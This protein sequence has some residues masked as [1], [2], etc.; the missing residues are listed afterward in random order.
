MAAQTDEVHGAH[1]ASLQHSVILCVYSLKYAKQSLT[2]EQKFVYTWLMSTFNRML[3]ILLLGV[4]YIVSAQAA[5]HALVLDIQGAIGSAVAEDVQQAL[6]RAK[7]ADSSLLILRMDTPGGLDLSMRSIIKDILASPVPVATFV[8]PK[9]ARAASAGTY[10][11]YASHIAAMAPA[12]NLGAATPVRIG[13]LPSISPPAKPGLKGK[14]EQRDG[15][16]HGDSMQHKMV[17]DAAAYM[18]GLAVLRGRNAD[19]AEKAVRQAASLNS[20]QA[21]QA[22]VIDVIAEDI[23]ALLKKLDGRTIDTSYG[24]VTL[25]SSNLA[26]EVVERNWRSRLLAI[27]SN[28]NVA[29]ILMLLAIYGLFFE[30]ANPGFVLPGIVGGVC[31][32]LALF[33]FQVLPVNLAGVGLITL[34]ILFMVGEVFAPSFG[35]LGLGGIIAFVV[36]SIMLMDSSV[37]GYGIS[38]ALIIGFTLSSVLFFVFTV[39]MAL[40]A[41]QRPVVSGAEEMLGTLAIA[42]DD[43]QANSG[44]VLA[45]GEIWQAEST[46]CL[47]KGDTVRI[48]RRDDLTL[49]VEP[50]GHES[51]EV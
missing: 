2:M 29:Y 11:L 39:G 42:H 6:N 48:I 31:L 16:T 21:L 13:G 35:A 23:P 7:E 17:N 19:W 36:G 18:R 22:Q 1:Q 20:R 34:G 46:Q 41:R 43:F 27:I 40:K 32:L 8:A 51:K 25:D 49:Y 3:M 10:I 14:P 4:M 24:P 9:G 5:P 28:P 15:E 33:A 50:A 45:H 47:S 44:H 12:T 30:L 26:I 38:P 37:P